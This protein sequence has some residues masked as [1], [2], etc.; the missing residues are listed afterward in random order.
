MDWILYREHKN[1]KLKRLGTDAGIWIFGKN[2]EKK[3]SS[4]ENVC[5]ILGLKP[6]MIRDRVR[7]LPEE[8]ARHLR[9]MEFGD[10]W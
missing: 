8:E 10:E 6:D 5:D 9:G 3:L 7:D 1:V 4:F 2:E